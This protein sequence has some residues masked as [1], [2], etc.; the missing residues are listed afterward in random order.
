MENRE[1]IEALRDLLDTTREY[2]HLDGMTIFG[3]A[4]DLAISALE[5]QKS[6]NCLGCQYEQTNGW[7]TPCGDCRRAHKDYYTAKLFDPYKAEKET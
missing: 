4:I 3:D 7:H 5:R 6:N 1:A 2:P